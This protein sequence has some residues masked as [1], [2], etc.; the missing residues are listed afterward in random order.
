VPNAGL[1]GGS[2]APPAIFPR[3][4]DRQVL[5]I[6]PGVP[7]PHQS[8]IAAPAVTVVLLSRQWE[9]G[10]EPQAAGEGETW[11]L[12]VERALPEQ[13]ATAPNATDRETAAADRGEGMCRRLGD[14]VIQVAKISAP[15]CRDRWHRN[16][17]QVSSLWVPVGG[18][19]ALG[20]GGV[21][22]LNTANPVAFPFSPKVHMLIMP[23]GQAS[24]GAHH[25]P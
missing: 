18:G 11:S 1:V 14:G 25:L 22:P 20:V 7:R 5:A 3:G 6:D 21:V 16:L 15:W 10:R 19:G 13:S 9:C 23:L 8:R 12:P 4:A 24:F 17:W 2:A